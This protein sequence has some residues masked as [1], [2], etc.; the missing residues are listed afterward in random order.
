MAYSES[1]KKATMRW[2]ARNYDKIQITAP[3]GF[4][5]RLTE[6]AKAADMPYRQFVLKALEKAM[7]E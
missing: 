6:A 7:E 3:K 5:Q 2:E 4:K 1:Q